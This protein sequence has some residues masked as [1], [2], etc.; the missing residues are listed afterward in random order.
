MNFYS[1]LKDKIKVFAN[2]FSLS[3]LKYKNH[4]KY[5]N[6]FYAF[7]GSS[8]VFAYY[9]ENINLLSHDKDLKKFMDFYIK[10]WKLSASQWSQD[11][12]VMYSTNMLKNGKF[13][14]IGG[15]DGFTCSNTFSL[16]KHLNWNGVIVEPDNQMFVSLQNSRKNNKLI[17]KVISPDGDNKKY[18]FRKLSQFSSISGYEGKKLEGKWKDKIVNFQTVN[19][20]SLNEVLNIYNFDYFSLD[21]EGAEID[22][23]K[24]VHWDKVKKP[25]L[26]T[27]ECNNYDFKYRNSIKNLL[28]TNGYQTCFENHEWLLRGDLWFKLL[29]N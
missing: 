1:L 12:F 20:I 26:I 8:E 29:E 21:I 23:L 10:N 11:I 15:A 16:E 27:V 24:S 19:G 3:L 28:V 13:L 2:R 22:C 25:K 6:A 4:I 5:V 17:K 14:E 9:I 18:S 7:A